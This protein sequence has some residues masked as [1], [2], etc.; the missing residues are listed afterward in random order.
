GTY[1]EYVHACGDDHLDAD[2]VVLRARRDDRETRKKQTE[3]GKRG[4]PAVRAPAKSAADRIRI[5]KR[6][7][8]LTAEIEAAEARVAEIDLTF[9][10]PGFYEERSVE[11]VQRLQREREELRARVDRLM[12]D[13]EEVETELESVA[14]SR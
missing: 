6:R 4:Q 8:E 10:G 3:N 2:T 11:E 14:A 1:E 12:Q 13:W 9:A 5:E 7:D